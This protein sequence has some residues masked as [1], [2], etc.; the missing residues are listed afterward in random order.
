MSVVSADIKDRDF[1]EWGLCYHTHAVTLLQ[2]S[3]FVGYGST[4]RVH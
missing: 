2:R 1:D 3:K 4:V